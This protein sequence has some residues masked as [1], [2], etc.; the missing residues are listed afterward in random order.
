[1][2][3]T[4]RRKSRSFVWTVGL[5][6]ILAFVAYKK[7]D[8]FGKKD[9]LLQ[10]EVQSNLHQALEKTDFPREV[11]FQKPSTDEK[12]QAFVDYTIDPNLQHQAET[13]LARYNPDYAAIVIMDASTG[14]I[15][16]LAQSS[17]KEHT[18][19]NLALS[20]AFPAAS[21]YKIVTAAAAIDQG[22]AYTETVI[23]FN[24]RN[25]TLY[26]KNLKEDDENR[27]TRRVTLREAF[28]RSIN[29]V[30]GKLGIFNVGP[31]DLEK[32]A[33]RF[34]FNKKIPSD[35]NVGISTTSISGDDYELAE[36]ASGFTLGNTLSPVHGAML[37]AA[38][39]NEGTLVAPYIVKRISDGFDRS[40]YLGKTRNLGPVITPYSAEQMKLLMR[41][42]VTH[43]TSRRFF[44]TLIQNEDQ[45]SFGGKTGSLTGRNP[46]GKCDW[47]VGYG[48]NQDR[49]I[50]ISILTVHEKYWTVKSSFLAKSLLEEIFKEPKTKDHYARK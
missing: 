20:S 19:G 26:K 13:L 12:A 46:N 50:A 2:P 34:Y 49:K 48:S 4:R 39:V 36:T 37:A 10:S 41:E 6:A 25:H 40:Q 11:L 42:T 7:F 21:V 44:R 23:P 47:F 32:Y 31:E 17:T 1:M 29:T 35:L 22:K 24:G 27:W 15:L 28:G 9:F 38:I 5:A 3:P 33:G 30:F 8:Y 16:S 43:G 45:V 14:E 18:L